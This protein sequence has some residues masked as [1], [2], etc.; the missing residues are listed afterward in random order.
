MTESPSRL[1]RIWRE[2]RAFLLFIALMFI[3]RSAIADWNTV[4]TG[5]MKPTIV[6]GDRIGVNKLAYDIRI[7]FTGISI[8][9]LAD[10]VRG[11][12]VVFDSE[13]SGIRLVK[14]VVGVPGDVIAMRNNVLTIN[15]RTFSYEAAPT[16]P[17]DYLELGTEFLPDHTIRVRRRG[18]SLA[19]F[20]PVTVPEGQ[21]FVLGDNRDDSAD[22]RVIGF[23]PRDEIVGRA[24]HVVMSLNYDNYYLPRSDRFFHTL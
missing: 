4:P 11:D 6:E 16:G 19:S 13:A 15:G 5:S 14:R 8:V 17:T 22:S 21:Y 9:R 12:I 2:N 7:P 10:P 24:R 23:V 1:R 18:S 3:F 20:D